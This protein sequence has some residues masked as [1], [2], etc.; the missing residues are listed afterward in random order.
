M[1]CAFLLLFV[2]PMKTF[3]GGTFFGVENSTQN[4]FS[5]LISQCPTSQLTLYEPGGT[6]SFLFVPSR[7]NSVRG[8]S[9]DTDIRRLKLFLC[10]V[11]YAFVLEMPSSSMSSLPSFCRWPMAR[12]KAFLLK[13]NFALISSGEVLS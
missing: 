2:R 13:P 6:N 11:L 12:L 9:T 4:S 8:V 7:A 10:K 3:R 1:V 5:L